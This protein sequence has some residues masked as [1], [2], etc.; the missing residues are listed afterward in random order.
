MTGPQVED[1]PSPSFGERRGG[2]RPELIVIHHTAMATAEAALARLADPAAEVSAHYVVAEDGRVWRMVAEEARA[3]HAGAGSWRGEADVN[4]RSIGIELANPGPVAGFPPFPEPQMVALEG[5]ID[6][7]RARWAI[8]EA[9]VIAH[10]DMAPGRKADPGPKLDW[11][12]LALG[13]RAVWPRP[14]GHG[15]G[16]EAFREGAGTAGYAAPEGDWEA[17]LAAFRLR[18][19]PWAKGPLDPFDVGT[20][21]ALAALTPAAAAT[22]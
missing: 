10:S 13:G 1:W 3:W 11:R 9:G 4:S 22:T 16:W 6:G 14:A 5:L 17:V 20:M 7:I 15:G 8:P 2:R 12:R 18:F 21:R 19:R